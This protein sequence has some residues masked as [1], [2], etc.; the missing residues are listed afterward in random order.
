[1]FGLPKIKGSGL[2]TRVLN[3]YDQYWDLKLGV[4]TFGHLNSGIADG[5]LYAPASYA[6]IFKVFDF[7]KFNTDDVLFDIGCGYGRPMLAAAYGYHLKEAVGIEA[8]EA[9]LDIARNN[10]SNLKKKDFP[11]RLES[12]LAQQADYQTATIIYMY[13]PFGRDTMLRVMDKLFSSLTASPRELRI[14]YLNPIENKL[15]MSLP[16]LENYHNFSHNDLP[17]LQVG[18]HKPGD[19]PAASLFRT[20]V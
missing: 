1:M 5:K 14:A 18:R 16:W 12:E 2:K 4:N 3:F 11:L 17:D 6:A 20:R 15:L 8:N 7:L 13:N 9:F 19:I 10:I